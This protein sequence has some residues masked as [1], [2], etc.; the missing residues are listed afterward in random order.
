MQSNQRN[1]IH[2][3]VSN[4]TVAVVMETGKATSR[5]LL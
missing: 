1:N 2:P 4:H 5:L 3:V